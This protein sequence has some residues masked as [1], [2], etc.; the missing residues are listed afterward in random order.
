MASSA[1]MLKKDYYLY[2]QESEVLECQ[3]S[4]KW[5]VTEALIRKIINQERKYE[6][7]S[8]IKEIK[9]KIILQYLQNNLAKKVAF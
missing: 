7:D 3:Y 1:L 9:N 5:Q 2:H 8:R 4:K 6:R